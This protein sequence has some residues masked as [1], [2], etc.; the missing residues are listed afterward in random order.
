MLMLE[1]RIEI[2]ENRRYSRRM[3]AAIPRNSCNCFRNILVPDSCLH[4]YTNGQFS[5]YI[6]M[7]MC[8]YVSPVLENNKFEGEML[9]AKAYLCIWKMRRH[10]YVYVYMYV[11]GCIAALQFQKYASLWRSCRT[12]TCNRLAKRFSCLH[13]YLSKHIHV[14]LYVYI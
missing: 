10:M 8:V 1:N 14:C 4:A 7:W 13:F 2:N 11:C 5:C 3:K 12:N 9:L 6:C